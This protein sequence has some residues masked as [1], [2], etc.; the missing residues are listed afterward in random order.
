VRIVEGLHPSLVIVALSGLGMNASVFSRRAAP[1]AADCRPFRAWN[2]CIRIVCIRI[3]EGLHPS[4]LI[5]AFS[6]LGMMMCVLS[7]GCTLRC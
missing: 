3:V 2:D 6:G 5:V 1:F 7:K 4:L